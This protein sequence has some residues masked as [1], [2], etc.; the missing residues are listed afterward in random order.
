MLLLCFTAVSAAHPELAVQSEQLDHELSEQPASAELLIRRGDIHRREGNYAAAEQDFSAARQLEP[1]NPDL[2]F[3]QARLLLDMGSAEEA[4]VLLGRW[5]T[6]H[7][8]QPTAWSLRGDARM[9]MNQPVAAAEA[10]ARAIELSERASPGVYLQQANAL[11]AAG[12]SHWQQALSVIN[13]GL[14]KFPLEVSLL[15]L[16]TD[17]ALDSA[18]PDLA[19]DYFERVP[20]KVRALPQ[21]QARAAR[22]SP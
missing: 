10:Y 8:D 22:L 1:D 18:Q 3:Y 9:Q 13:S 17:I 11:H 6:L 21:W 7:P 19:E 2:D 5:I 12:P 4:D 14:E 20:T 15:G 16:G